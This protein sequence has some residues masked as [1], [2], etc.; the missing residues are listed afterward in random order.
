MRY[1]FDVVHPAH[2]H[3]F[4]HLI[5][6]L[7]SAGHETFV[8]ARN[9]DVTTELLDHH[10]IEYVTVKRSRRRGRL[11][12]ATE[13]VRRDLAL[14]RIIR[15]FGAEVLLTR[16]P[17]GVQ[18]ARLTGVLGI[19]DTDDGKQVGVHFRAAARF[20]HVITTPD[21][22]A[23]DLGARHVKY[24]SY[25]ALAFLHPDRF[26]ADPSVREQLGVHEGDRY[27]IVRTV[28]LGASHDRGAVGFDPDLLSNVLQVLRRHGPAFVSSETSLPP[29]LEPFALP[30]PAH[31]VH[32]ALAFAALCVTDGQSMAG[33]AAVLGVPSIR[34]SS[35]SG[36]LDL[37]RELGERYGMVSEFRPDERS[38]FLAEVECVAARDDRRAWQEGRRILLADKCDLTTWLCDFLADL[39]QRGVSP[40]GR[41]RARGLR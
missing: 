15:D 19:F 39:P 11:G 3:F 6:E 13:L 35:T 9:K 31:R 1:L 24:P 28:A 21:C 18:A 5:G 12:L 41:R 17:A 16:N 14:R 38:A 36:R 20:A 33:E 7:G 8:V 2:V 34:F 32:D 4:R 23:D 27:S 30:V 29:D 25:K 37:F 40:R 10:R 22:I 26:A